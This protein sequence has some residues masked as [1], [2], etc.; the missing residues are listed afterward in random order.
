MPAVIV[1]NST[2]QLTLHYEAELTAGV[3]EGHAV[4]A[5]TPPADL[6]SAPT[7][8]YILQVR[9]YAC[10]VTSMR[11][12]TSSA[13]RPLEDVQAVVLPDEP[14]EHRYRLPPWPTAGALEYHLTWAQDPEGPAIGEALEER[15]LFLVRLLVEDRQGDT[16]V[17]EHGRIA[18]TWTD[19]APAGARPLADPGDG[20]TL[21]APLRAAA[22][23]LV[24]ADAE[25]VPGCSHCAMV[26]ELRL[27]EQ[28]ERVRELAEEHHDAAVGD[29]VA[30]WLPDPQDAF[31]EFI[32]PCRCVRAR[33]GAHPDSA[34]LWWSADPATRQ[35]LDAELREH[36]VAARRRHV[37]HYLRTINAA[38][39][40]P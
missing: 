18:V 6:L 14:R 37:I 3:R 34:D 23:D 17:L 12:R 29:W 27:L 31:R 26:W 5:V 25:P 1:F 15:V 19:P 40:S 33:L 32:N 8:A 11:L 16:Q 22:D 39:P 10:P 35:R 24:Q 38:P 36:L 20:R 4:I 9:R 13:E 30:R 7:P 21:P 2:G 28:A